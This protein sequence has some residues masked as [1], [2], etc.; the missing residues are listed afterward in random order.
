MVSK[1]VI[2]YAYIAALNVTVEFGVP[3]SSVTKTQLNSWSQ[4]DLEVESSKIPGL[5]NYVGRFYFN[6]LLNGQE[7]AYEY[8][9]INSWTGNLDGGS[10]TSIANTKCHRIGNLIVTYG[11][12][13][14]GPGIAG[15]T[16]KDQ[17]WVT[18]SM[19]Q[20]S[21]M[22]NIA[23]AGSLRAEKLFAT[24]ALPCPHDCGMNSMQSS[25]VVLNSS[26]AIFLEAVLANI[27]I[28]GEAIKVFIASGQAGKVIYG[29]AITQKE[30]VE[31]M[32]ALGARYFEFRPGRFPEL[33]R[34]QSGL[35]DNYYYMHS[36]IPG[37]AYDE[38]LDRT[39][40]FLNQHPQEIIVIQLRT[41]GIL[42]EI[43]T[44]SAAEKIDI[45][46]AALTRYPGISSSALEDMQK[47]TIRQLRESSK[48]LIVL[49]EVDQYS[50]YN[51]ILY[52][53][54]DGASI[55]TAL[56]SITSAGQAGRPLTLLQCQA[57]ATN[58]KDALVYSIAS[59]NS[60]TSILMSTKAV[61]DTKTHP[62]LL[63]NVQ[64]LTGRELVVVM[65]DFFDGA[66]ADITI[67]LNEARFERTIWT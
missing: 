51:D 14:A 10:M 32:L 29:L 43:E 20:S 55:I 37:M 22:S 46:N 19:D 16:D 8:N 17:C 63:A 7:I 48:R 56:N 49:D 65:N 23:P 25:D 15:L 59:S 12:Y 30:S 24:F 38:F 45:L 64:N 58:V 34:S 50:S 27:P 31:D 35:S 47:S 54:L 6:V 4:D 11:F 42:D 66:T 44:P 28:V 1:G 62:W 57:T 26:A 61:A 9:D 53:T 33:V 41:D 21:W 67:R 60:S 13:D 5:F 39:L 40:A 3:G 52:A 2:A 36:C 18:V